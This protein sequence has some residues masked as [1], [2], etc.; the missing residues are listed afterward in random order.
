MLEDGSYEEKNRGPCQIC[1]RLIMKEC[2]GLI[3]ELDRLNEVQLVNAGVCPCKYITV[4][5]LLSKPIQDL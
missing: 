2:D 3:Y 1:K 4:E 5:V